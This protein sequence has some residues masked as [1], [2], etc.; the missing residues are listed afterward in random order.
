MA[1][2]AAPANATEGSPTL[3]DDM[4][5]LSYRLFRHYRPRPV[6]INVYI[7]SNNTVTEVDPD[8]MSIIWRESDR[9]SDTIIGCPT[10]SHVFWGGHVAETVTSAEAAL[11][12]A[13]GYT[14]T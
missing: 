11:L 3:P 1:T 13:A 6:G 10:V 14:V 12:T 2:F 5:S 9:T 7:L 8:G 4:R